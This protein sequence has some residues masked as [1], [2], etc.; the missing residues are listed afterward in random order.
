MQCT[1]TTSEAVAVADSLTEEALAVYKLRK[2]GKPPILRIYIVGY[3]QDLVT[4]IY[5]YGHSKR[6]AIYINLLRFM[7]QICGSK[8][9]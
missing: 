3:C 2:L 7:A 8:R 9:V 5:I 1:R 6:L 4:T